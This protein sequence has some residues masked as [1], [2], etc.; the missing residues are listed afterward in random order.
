M[1]FIF[2]IVDLKIV[3]INLCGF[4]DRPSYYY[5]EVMD[6]RKSCPVGSMSGYWAAARSSPTKVTKGAAIWL[7]R[8]VHLRM[9]SRGQSLWC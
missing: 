5:Y 8:S 6:L 1:N 3:Q 9:Y 2:I 7:R 4:K